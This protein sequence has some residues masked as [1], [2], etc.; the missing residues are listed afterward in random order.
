[1]T[2]PVTKVAILY[3]GTALL[4]NSL[5]DT[6]RQSHILCT[7][8]AFCLRHTRKFQILCTGIEFVF[9]YSAG[10]TELRQRFRLLVCVTVYVLNV[11]VQC[12][13]L[14]NLCNAQKRCRFSA[15]GQ[16]IAHASLRDCMRLDE[17]VQFLLT[18][19][20]RRHRFYYVKLC[21]RMAMHGQND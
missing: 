8:T 4:F 17:P 11:P 16:R 14:N 21:R 3:T 5:R 13:Y 1:M 7:G 2:A 15:Q 6:H 12:L 10:R 9:N 20:A 18:A 19:G